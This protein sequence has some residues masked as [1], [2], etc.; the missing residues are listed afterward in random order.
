MNVDVKEQSE[1]VEWIQLSEDRVQWQTVINTIIRFH[2]RH[3]IS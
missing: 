2:K 1:A 3:G